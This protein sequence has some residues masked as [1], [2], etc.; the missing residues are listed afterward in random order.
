[1]RL[2]VAIVGAGIGAAHL[3]GY[4]ANP[5]L[6]DVVAIADLDH[7]R[8]APLVERSGA[9]YV[10]SLDLVVG[11]ADI[12]LIDICLPP[13][14]HK[15]AIL[16]CLAEGK[17]VVCEKPLVGSLK[18]MDDVE[19]AAADAERQATPVVMPVFQY[20][21]GQGIG[22]LVHLIEQGLA[23]RP[24]VATLETHWNRGADYYAVPWR[25]KWESELGGAIVGHAIHSHDLLINVLGPVKNV[26]A[27][28]TTSVNPIDVEDCAAII[29]ETASGA[30]VTSSVTLGSADD[31][32]RLRF[33][34]SDL[35]AE[36]GTEPYNPG[37]AP[38]TFKARSPA[39]QA[40][41]TATLRTY[42]RHAE[43][44]ARQFE[45]MHTAIVNG[46]P[47]PVTLADARASLELI[48]AIY[49][50]D[51]TGRTV[52]LPLKGDALGYADWTP[53]V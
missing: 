31:R 51:K 3:D 9:I 52:S 7:A 15:P 5:E 22:Q 30:L 50:A 48:T 34:F 13:K 10:P 16:A 21:F 45:Q 12:D 23:G 24:L 39:Q 25:G 19:A 37:T 42:P 32:S 27:R 40:E 47:P 6:F 26:Q 20:R 18:D 38:W 11:R 14:L 35:T 4:L 1:M 36:S 33:C 53:K 2:R 46:G 41:I 44:F 43:G 29:M 49:Q 17:H 28:L 8:A